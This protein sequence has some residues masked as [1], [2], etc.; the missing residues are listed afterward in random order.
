MSQDPHQP[1][2]PNRPQAPHQV[3]NPYPAQQAPDPHGTRQQWGQPNQPYPSGTQQQWA[4]PQTQAWGQMPPQGPGQ[5]LPVGYGQPG[6]LVP[7]T[8]PPVKSKTKV[9][10]GWIL[11]VWTILGVL[12][13]MSRMGQGTV[14]LIHPNDVAR[15]V[16]SLLGLILFN[17]LPGWGAW[18]LLTSHRRKMEKWQRA[19]G[20]GPGMGWR[21]PGQ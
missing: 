4:E 6:G 17:V 14:T 18:A 11:L 13:L 7:T 15:S 19:Q 2:D 3:N 5:N 10:F 8:P 16:G 9:V 12:S 21:Q 1:Q 20:I